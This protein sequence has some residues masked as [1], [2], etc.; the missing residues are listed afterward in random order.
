MRE[1]PVTTLE[2]LE[3]IRDERSMAEAWAAYMRVLTR[4]P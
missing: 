1:G 2:D 3:R 4:R